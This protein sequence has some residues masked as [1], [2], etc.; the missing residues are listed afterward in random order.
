M[1]DSGRPKATEPEES[2]VA[3]A[4]EVPPATVD[5]VAESAFL[6]EARERG[7]TVRPS[8]SAVAVE[9]VEETDPKSLPPLDALVQRIPAEV[10]ETLDDL[11]RAR[12]V[13]VQRIPR[14][15]LKP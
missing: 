9:A 4:D 7:E 15:A 12:F 1:Q 13:R 14:R 3:V 8:P 11:F 6:A 5:E 10:R 2:S